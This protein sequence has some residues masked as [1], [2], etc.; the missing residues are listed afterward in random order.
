MNVRFAGR[1]LLTGLVLGYAFDLLFDS[2]MPGVSVFLFAG[3]LLAGLAL[4]AR[5]ETT[6][7]IRATLWLPLALLLFAGAS[8]VRASGFLIFLNV[9]TC[10]LL[11]S[12]IAVCQMHAPATGLGLQALLSAPLQAM[13]LSLYH[14]VRVASKA[15]RRDSP[16]V[17]RPSRRR[18]LPV[19]RG[20]LLAVPILI[21]FAAL[22]ASADL[23]FA[24][25]LERV[26]RL[27]FLEGLWRWSGHMVV[28]VL[29][30]VPVAGGLAYAVRPR[31]TDLNAPLSWLTAPRFLGLTES[32]VVIHSVNAL[33][34]FFVGI[35][36]PYL[37]GGLV[38]IT[39]A[40]Q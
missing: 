18:A 38:N 14:G 30:G 13:G 1:L 7:S 3:L 20:L 9:S 22:L 33:F 11:L 24:E 4:A 6:G 2:S 16:V 37:F 29:V 34:L 23:I 25:L 12:L 28:I 8:L 17:P 15:L 21:V 35:Q 19:L 36:V 27:E 32:T 5:G 10:L 39:A 31:Q 26:V 40:R